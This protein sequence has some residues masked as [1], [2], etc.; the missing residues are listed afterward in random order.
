MVNPILNSD[1]YKSSHYLQYPPGTERVSSYIEARGTEG[2]LPSNA[3][4]VFFGL[5]KFLKDLEPIASSEIEEAEEVLT[6]H[7]EPFNAEGWWKIWNDHNGNLPI[8]ISAL[9]EGTASPTGHALVQVVN[10]DTSL[11][12]VTSYV[13]TALLRAVWYPTTV[14]TLSREA[15][16]IIRN[17][18]ILTGADLAGL[19]FKLHDFGARGV[20]SE[21]SAAIGGMAH[22]VNFMGSDTLSGVMA[23]RKY[24]SEKMAGF[25][26]PAAEHSTITSWASEFDAYNNM[27]DKFPKGLVAVVSDSYDLMNA[28][29]NIWGGQLK[30]KV[31]NRDGLLV[32]RPDSGVPADIV[33]STVAG[34][35]ER[36]GYTQ[37]QKGYKVLPPY[38]RVIQ[39]DGITLESIPAIL[40]KLS[41]NGWSADN[42]AFGMGGGLLQQ[43]NRDTLRFAMKASA[44][45]VNGAWRNIM[46]NPKTDPGKRSKPGRLGVMLENGNYVTKDINDVPDSK[47][48]LTPVWRNGNLLRETTFAEIRE[49]AKL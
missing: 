42:V 22:L 13:E 19:P 21:E 32:V 29:H 2:P 47:N 35:G 36:F 30:Q 39:G 33:L 1:S 10:T 31:A 28:V 26:I 20:S 11:P 6:A 45:Q 46:K 34:L 40:T 3:E 5:Q 25:S 48:L 8:E 4:V 18:M 14:A 41:L 49:R 15:K 37:N 44:I 12:W 7:G 17:F 24:Y 16:K 38:I 43:V 9:P 27:L 23:A